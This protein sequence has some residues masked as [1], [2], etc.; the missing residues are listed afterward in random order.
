M[1]ILWICPTLLHPTI[2]G[3]QIRTLGILRHLSRKNEVHFVGT[4]RH[5]QTTEQKDEYC[6]LVYAFPHQPPQRGSPAFA[7]DALLNLF[8]PTPLYVARYA[9]RPASECVKRLLHENTYDAV[10]V[11]FLL[12]VPNLPAARLENAILF[13]H[14][15]EARIM[16]R[17]A[18]ETTSAPRRAYLSYMARRVE[19]YERH[20]CSRV[21][22]VITVSPADSAYIAE[23]YGVK[24]VTSIAT[25][26]NVRHFERPDGAIPDAPPSDLVFI[27]SMDYLPN[28]QGVH[29]FV[30]RVL[31]LIHASRP[32]ATVALVGKYPDSTIQALAAK[33]SRIHV[34]GTVPDVRPYLWNAGVSIVPLLAGS[35]TRLKIYEAMAAGVPVI[36]TSL[37]AEGL[38]YTDG[39]D[40]VLASDPEAFAAACL[41]LLEHRDRRD[42][43]ASAGH[44]LVRSRF[45]WSV[46][47]EEFQGILERAAQ[48]R[49]HVH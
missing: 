7:V 8:S 32:A 15:V 13:Q 5:G 12:S 45:D 39:T 21:R 16:G 47:A 24:D 28:V 27:G 10:V 35:G 4:A 34:T 20:A 1:R 26:V 2:N 43:I 30:E 49:A 18:A 9:S 31:P 44:T 11:D 38:A 19:Q 46:V 36:S 33:D 6:S 14:N 48:N 41:E 42:F 29:W 37:G 23:H 3:S 40:I 22:H 17:L 25:G